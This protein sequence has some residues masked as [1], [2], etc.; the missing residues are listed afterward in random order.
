MLV[1]YEGGFKTTLFGGKARFNGSV[2]YYDYTDYQIFQF[3]GTSGAVFNADA[4]YIGLELDMAAQP[5]DNF[6][7]LFG[8]SW[9]DAEV[10]DVNVAPGLPRDVEPTFTPEFQTS[11]LARYTF[12]QLLLN[13]DVAL[14]M[15][16][17]HASE[18]FFNINNFGTHEM[19]SYIVGNAR[20][21]WYHPND[22]LEVQFFVNNLADERYQN[23]GFELSTIC[24]CDERSYGRPRWFGGRIR[25][26]F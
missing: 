18:A 8:F 25:Y 19:E 23:I 15:D 6:D 24:G 14:Q 12:P 17:N 7:I 9:I 16:Y 4:N 3:I 1:A 5:F 22:Q 11:G 10:E 2:Y 26:S 21:T 20:V 13:G